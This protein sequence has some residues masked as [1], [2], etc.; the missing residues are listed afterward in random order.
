MNEQQ[1]VVTV[2]TI[3]FRVPCRS[4]YIR[5]N[6]T[7]DRPL[8]V[9]D[10]FVLRLLRVCGQLTL[11]RVG[12]FFG[13]TR[14]ET[15]R[16]IEDLL[17]KELAVAEG[18]ELRLSKTAAELFRSSAEEE[19][20]LVEVE[21]WT[22]NIWLDLVGRT[23]VPRPRQ[24]PFRNL[25]DV[26]PDVD[27]EKSPA[28][29]A[30]A[31]FE[32]NFRDYVTRTR[33]V[34]DPDKVS[35]HSIASLEPD[36]YGS[37]I[38]GARKVLLKGGGKLRL[39]FDGFADAPAHYRNLI[40]ELSSTY[41]QLD[42]PRALA[43]SLT[44]FE[45]LAAVSLRE[46]FDESQAF[47]YERWIA[48]RPSFS[49]STTTWIAGAI[50][51]DT[52]VRELVAHLE[53]LEPNSVKPELKWLRPAGGTWGMTSDLAEALS[54]LRRTLRLPDIPRAQ[55]ATLVVPKV[56]VS[57]TVKRFNRLFEFAEHAPSRTASSLEILVAGKAAAMVL[58]HVPV[59]ARETLPI[60][61]VTTQHKFLSRLTA[62]M[63]SENPSLWR[64][65]P[66]KGQDVDDV[67]PDSTS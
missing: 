7:R 36:R 4:F 18:E 49:D 41:G 34:P 66:R 46:Y 25:V 20:R 58:I 62:Y 39:E 31:A 3:G 11:A 48:H 14:S 52:N 33:R 24:R 1:D 67:E 61:V 28:D 54:L 21:A 38:I 2:D 43:T 40:Q 45:R 47:D 60:G 10:E 63:G 16:V 42:Q 29:H 9:V 27:A 13:F 8:P 53:K 26:Q 37:V 51:L 50:Y 57:T 55:G 6:V 32:A 56:A 17:S 35:I 15:E 59:D 30:R 22:E 23:L 64:T 5:A 44:D 12:D 19:P 65:L